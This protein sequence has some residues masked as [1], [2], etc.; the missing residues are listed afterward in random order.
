M[1]TWTGSWF[2]TG[3]LIVLWPVLEASRRTSSS[4]QLATINLWRI[5]FGCYNMPITPSSVL[6]VLLFIL[7]QIGASL[8]PTWVPLICLESSWERKEST[9]RCWQKLNLT[10]G[11]DHCCQDWKPTCAKQQLCKVWRVADANPR[12]AAWGA[13]QEWCCLDSKQN[14]SQVESFCDIYFDQRVSYF[15]DRLG[16]E[17]NDE[18][19][20]YYWAA[21]WVL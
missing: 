3:W 17:I 6:I 12:Q 14:H 16:L 8:Q 20:I 9:G 2:S 15:C 5:A 21:K 19:S 11:N 18:S 13:K 7:H 10:D 4:I 1:S